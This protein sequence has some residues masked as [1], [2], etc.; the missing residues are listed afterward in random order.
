MQ[1]GTETLHTRFCTDL[2]AQS[3][4]TNKISASELRRKFIKS[5]LLVGKAATSFQKRCHFALGMP[6]ILPRT[7]NRLEDGVGGRRG[8]HDT[9]F[10][11]PSYITS[12]FC[13]RPCVFFC[14]G[15]FSAAA[16]TKLGGKLFYCA[17]VKKRG[18]RGGGRGGGG[19]REGQFNSSL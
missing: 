2:Y 17:G 8:N 4:F 13:G 14:G 7:M 9:L 16:A 15:S 1:N 12:F 19:R 6:S 18:E 5:A 11:I 3:V 10:R